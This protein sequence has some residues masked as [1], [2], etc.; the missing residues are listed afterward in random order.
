MKEGTGLEGFQTAHP[1]RFFDVGIAEE[2]A[3]AMAGGMAAQG[4]VP[5][6]AV[7][8]TFLQRSY[9]MLIH[10]VALMNLHVVLGVDRAGI[11][12]K[13]GQ[14]HQ[15]AF[16]VAFLSSVPGVTIYAPASFSELE[17]MLERA[18]LECTGPVAVRYPRG[19]EGAFQGDTS[20]QPMAVLTQGGDVTLVSYGIEI[21]ECLGA[22]TALAEE[23]IA[24][25]VVK[26]NRLPPVDAE[27]VI[28]SVRR[29]GCLV[30]AE[31]VCRAGGIGEQ[32]LAAL[33]QAG[34][35]VKA[36]RRLDLGDG[37]LENGSPEQLRTKI[38]LDGQGIAQAI[39][40]CMDE[41]DK[42]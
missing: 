3:C 24:V 9:D 36:A 31:D 17:T 29:T 37:I 18:V 42:T 1:D 12:G 27:P 23:N 35:T 7:Y 22:A 38:G 10:D 28:A 33:A 16:D 25:Q 4:L 19:G 13:D 39:R 32:V 21:N 40:E 34:V 8:S 30:V 15:G 26:V 14:T 11:V 2:H 41:K 6:F 20:D 5:V